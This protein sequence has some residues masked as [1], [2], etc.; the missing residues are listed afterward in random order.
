M[1]TDL[2]PLEYSIWCWTCT[3]ACW[4]RIHGQS[5]DLRFL[6]HSKTVRRRSGTRACTCQGEGRAAVAPCG[7]AGLGRCSMDGDGRVGAGLAAAPKALCAVGASSSCAAWAAVPGGDRAAGWP[8]AGARGVSVLAG[9]CSAVGRARGGGLAGS[10]LAWRRAGPGRRGFGGTGLQ[11]SLASPRPAGIR[12]SAS[13]GL[14]W[15]AGASPAAS[16]GRRRGCAA[17]RQPSAAWDGLTVVT[18]R[19]R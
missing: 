11:L 3:V 4:A 6:A 19:P 15:C 14:C 8:A 13:G 17:A 9:A 2:V 5:G 18:R 10:G 16:G 12:W 7:R 1:P